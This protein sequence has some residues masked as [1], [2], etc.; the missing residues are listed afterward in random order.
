[1]GKRLFLAIFLSSGVTGIECANLKCSRR[2]EGI[3]FLCAIRPELGRR[4]S[5]QKPDASNFV[6]S[7]L[8]IY[9]HTVTLELLENSL[10]TFFPCS[11]RDISS[12]SE[13]LYNTLHYKHSKPGVP[14]QGSREF[15]GIS[16]NF[17][18]RRV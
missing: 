12:F 4:G 5:G 1:M 16:F 3:A 7:P 13:F 17:T 10:E 14:T 6:I 9:K 15:L 11:F 18:D 8:D 2:V